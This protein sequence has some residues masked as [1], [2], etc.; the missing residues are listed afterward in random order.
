MNLKAFVIGLC[1][2]IMSL[3]TVVLYVQMTRV[4]GTRAQEIEAI[5][6]AAVIQYA[7][8]LLESRKDLLSTFREDLGHD[9]R[10]AKEYILAV[11]DGSLGQIKHKIEL[12]RK[13]VGCD[14]VDLVYLSKGE[15]LFDR[16]FNG[17]R[18]MLSAA[19]RGESGIRVINMHGDL[20]FVS[21]SPLKLYHDSIGMLVLGYYLNRGL[22]SVVFEATKTRVDF[23]ANDVN[24]QRGS[25][26]IELG[27]AGRVA[28]AIENTAIEGIHRKI[29]TDL[30]ATGVLSLIVVAIA[31][32]FILELGLLRG[33][34][35]VLS[36]IRRGTEALDRGVILEP[37]KREHP[38][39]EVAT[40]SQAFF[41][42]GS[43]LKSYDARVQLK[44]RTES[45]G[46]FASQMAHDIKGKVK[47]LEARLRLEGVGDYT[48][49][50][51]RKIKTTFSTLRGLTNET[52]RKLKVPTA[53]DDLTFMRS[54]EPM[55][56]EMLWL[57]ADG[58]IADKTTLYADYDQVSLE[59]S[60]SPE[61]F[62]C[63]ASVQLEELKRILAN[64]IDNAVEA[65]GVRGRIT[66][67]VHAVGS[68][69][70]IRVI[71]DGRGIAEAD[72][73]KL[74]VRGESFAKP[75]GSGLGLWGARETVRR[76][77]GDIEIYSAEGRGT[78]VEIRLGAASPP[79]HLISDL[80]LSTDSHVLILDDDEAI[81]QMWRDRFKEVF[82]GRVTPRISHFLKPEE[83]LLWRQNAGLPGNFV[84]LCDFEFPKEQWNGL[85]LIEEL[86][87]E[88]RSI[89]V[90]WHFENRKLRADCE[91]RGIRMLSKCIA[92]FVP[93]VVT[94]DVVADA[95]SKQGSNA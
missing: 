6:R 60:V 20:A 43:G 66:I 33:L 41:Q 73:S 82:R 58:V 15:A 75:T 49:E 21:F 1:A 38:I 23:V 54:S 69:T 36:D 11:S 30:L 50:E 59:L 85:H 83:L 65:V 35:G 24:G 68:L 81:H 9:G 4:F 63:F 61:A 56:V 79:P 64:L 91:A 37:V 7:R 88:V 86:G 71:D 2:V 46:E 92:A 16:G 22:K 87:A 45:I 72:R 17:E 70:V 14:F 52:L 10:F 28:V 5:H 25:E 77:G 94:T 53:D 95:S 57:V 80:S 84:L 48:D 67:S 13:R 3:L 31:L 12:F 47:T 32:Y 34:G 42:Y 62:S 39:R 19:R 44:T 76:W 74:F 26:F 29:R 55:S 51:K 40:L 89:L 27:G 93:I 78:T 18:D 90:T 8:T